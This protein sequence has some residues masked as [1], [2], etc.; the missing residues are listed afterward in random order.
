MNTLFLKAVGTV[1]S[2]FLQ[3][4]GTLIQNA[5]AQGV[6]DSVEVFPEFVRGL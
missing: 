4:A 1:H 2:P 6:E 5:M 3:A